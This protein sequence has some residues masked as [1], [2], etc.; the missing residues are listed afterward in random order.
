MIDTIV[1]TLQPNQFRIMD[2]NRFNPSTIGLFQAPYYRLGQRSNFKCVQNPSSEELKNK[3]YKPRLTITRRMGD[4]TFITTMRIEF[5]IPKLLFGNNFDEVEESQF[6]AIISHLYKALYNMGVLVMPQI[7]REASI[8]AV[9]YSKNIVL[10][11]YSMPSTIL[12][13][14]SKI[15]LNLKLDLNQTDFRNEGH[16]LRFRANSFEISLYDKRK[17]LQKAKISDKRAIERDNALQLE[18]FDQWKPRAPFEVLRMEIRLNQRVKIKQ[19]FKKIGIDHKPTFSSIFKSAIAQKVLLFYLEQI[20]YGYAL[21][22]YRSKTIKDFIADFR[23][24]NPKTKIRKM[25]QMLALK[26]A[27]E[28]MGIREFREITA[29]YGSHNWNRLKKDLA[30]Y[31]FPEG[32]YAILKPIEAALRDY[33]PLRLKEF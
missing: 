24:N 32:D 10:T 17:D 13:E 12:K 20:K 26:T 19:V 21:L 28:E 3:I 30:N 29:F 22:A 27:I 9:H 7:L 16:S 1:L 25:L 8:S 31:R 5:S 2:H 4:R 15:N 23:I 14:L 33:R 18:L 6:E 11:D